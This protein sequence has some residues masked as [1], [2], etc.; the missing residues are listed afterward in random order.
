MILNLKGELIPDAWAE[1]YRFF[2]IESGYYC[3]ADV[4]AAIAALAD[5]EE[6]VLEINS[7]GGSVDDAAEIY[8]ALE[9]CKNPTKAEIQSL[10]GSAASYLALSCD[11]VEISTPAQMMIHLASWEIG[12]NKRD[13][14]WAAQQLDSTDLSI[15]D[16]Y[17]RKCGEA[18]RE[19][20][21]KLMEAETYLTARQ[22]L[23]LGLV[24]G[25][26]G[27]AQE[28]EEPMEPLALV[29]SAYS[30]AVRAMRT[31]PDIRELKERRE[32]RLREMS[33]ELAAEK[34]RYQ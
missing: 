11:R 10:A 23:E 2:G 30:N 14:T 26:I 28:T 16:T 17:C 5:G 31:L 24:D 8:S 13:H 34:N 4:K 18:R 12:G 21:R 7:I 3:P 15:L 19:E 22:C 1:V 20:L 29:A 9:K 27:Q 33:E 32:N 6:L 25:I